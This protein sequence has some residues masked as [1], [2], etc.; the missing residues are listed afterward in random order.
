MKG[1]HVPSNVQCVSSHAHECRRLHQTRQY[2]GLK[3]ELQE[4]VAIE[5]LLTAG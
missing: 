1:G 5:V 2:I 4:P 3:F